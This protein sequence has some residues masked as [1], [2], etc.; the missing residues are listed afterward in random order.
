MKEARAEA[1]KEI[2]EYR[3]EKEGEF[4]AFE[5]DVP[6]PASI[7]DGVGLIRATA[8]QRKQ[9]DGGGR[10]QRHRTEDHRD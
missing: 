9:E 6:L 10:Q 4:K 5:K 3:K 7:L 2:E 1:Q 8:L